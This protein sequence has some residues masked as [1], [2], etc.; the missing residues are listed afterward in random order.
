MNHKPADQLAS[1]HCEAIDPN[2]HHT[3]TAQERR[4]EHHCSLEA[5]RWPGPWARSRNVDGCHSLSNG[6]KGRRNA[7][8]PTTLLRVIVETPATRR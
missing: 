4:R 8:S 2:M 6:A 3:G 1:W 7:P 5:G